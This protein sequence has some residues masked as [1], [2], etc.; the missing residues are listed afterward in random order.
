MVGKVCQS[1]ETSHDYDSYV[2]LCLTL[3]Y[4]Y[5]TYVS[6]RLVLCHSPNGTNFYASM[7]IMQETERTQS[8]RHMQAS[9]KKC[10]SAAIFTE[11]E[12][13]LNAVA[14]R[15]S[16]MFSGTNIDE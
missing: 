15:S 11:N 5:G 2:F 16:Y 14:F 7:R 8:L 12:T 1:D 4:A 9:K 10:Y 13:T 3:R 6:L